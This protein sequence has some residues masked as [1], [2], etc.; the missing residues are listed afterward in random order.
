MAFNLRWSVSKT[1][2]KCLWKS[3]TSLSPAYKTFALTLIARLRL[4]VRIGFQACFHGV[5][6]WWWMTFTNVDQSQEVRLCFYDWMVRIVW[7]WLSCCFCGWS[8]NGSVHS[9]D[10]CRLH[11]D[12]HC[13]LHMF[14]IYCFLRFILVLVYFVLSHDLGCA[15]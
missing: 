4:P 11:N 5:H 10:L 7:C 2:S 3:W 6:H 1:S 15:S 13:Q 12:Q 14:A 9:T 8:V